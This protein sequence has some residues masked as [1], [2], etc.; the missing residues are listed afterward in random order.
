MSNDPAALP[1][2]PFDELLY[3]VKACRWCGRL[4]LASDEWDYE[5]EC[6]L[7]CER[8]I[9]AVLEDGLASESVF[10]GDC[11]HCGH[12]M[13]FYREVRWGDYCR[14]DECYIAAQ[15]LRALRER[16]GERVDID[17]LWKRDRGLCHLCG[18]KVPRPGEPV[19]MRL[20]ATV[21]HIRPIAR[22]GLH[23][24]ANVALA[25]RWCNSAKGSTW[26]GP[27]PVAGGVTPPRH[28]SVAE[29]RPVVMEAL[30][31]KNCGRPWERPRAKGRKPHHCP[32]CRGG[33]TGSHPTADPAAS[34]SDDW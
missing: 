7:N 23:E 33:V 9:D 2:A 27:E 13:A 34:T 11:T 32:D 5:I 10:F 31:C 29:S 26:A 15:G 25:H 18:G 19:D 30:I 16:T 12:L 8:A 24:W 28:Q 6:T 1:V 20:R 4:H 17:R 3:M 14:R 22:G 21:D